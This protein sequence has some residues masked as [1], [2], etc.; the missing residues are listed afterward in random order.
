MYSLGW[1]A[2]HCANEFPTQPEC[3]RKILLLVFFFFS[4]SGP[5]EVNTPFLFWHRLRA[6]YLSSPTGWVF[7]LTPSSPLVRDAVDAATWA[8]RQYQITLTTPVSGVEANKHDPLLVVWLS[9]MLFFFFLFFFPIGMVVAL[10]FI[11]LNPWPRL[12]Y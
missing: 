1:R 10:P 11:F 3:I 5:P 6:S 9:D 2:S 12:F 8:W 4:R 7:P